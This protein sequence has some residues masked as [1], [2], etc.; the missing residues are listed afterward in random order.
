MFLGMC[1]YQPHLS[2]HILPG[3]K[4]YL[5]QHNM[6]KQTKDKSK[7]LYCDKHFTKCPTGPTSSN[8]I[9]DIYTSMRCKCHVCKNT[10]QT[11]FTKQHNRKHPPSVQL[12]IYFMTK[13][14]LFSIRCLKDGTV[15]WKRLENQHSSCDM[16]MLTCLKGTWLL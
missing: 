10:H 3:S 11:C 15:N 14:Q 13:I 5:S 1:V 16:N 7:F 8:R 4:C 12:L 9:E 6:E 2:D